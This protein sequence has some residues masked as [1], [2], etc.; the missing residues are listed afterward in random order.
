MQR[1]IYACIRHGTIQ[2]DPQVSYDRNTSLGSMSYG[3]T[4]EKKTQG[5]LTDQ[6]H[7]V[8]IC[9]CVRSLMIGHESWKEL[10]LTAQEGQSNCSNL[11]HSMLFKLINLSNSHQ[12]F[13]NT[14]TKK[15][16]I[17]EQIAFGLNKNRI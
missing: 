16:Y 12:T 6:P 3:G 8:P 10:W 15:K 14:C 2:W 17:N 13:I 5:F 1:I 11:W 4:T 7:P 9:N